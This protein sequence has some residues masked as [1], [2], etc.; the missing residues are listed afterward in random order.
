MNTKF[1]TGSQ[2]YA[3]EVW[4]KYKSVSGQEYEILPVLKESHAQYFPHF[5]LSSFPS[6][7]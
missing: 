2:D 5:T 4:K 1:C 3:A 7:T 6:K